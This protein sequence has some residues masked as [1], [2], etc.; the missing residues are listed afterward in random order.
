HGP[1]SCH[2]AMLFRH[3]DA[4]GTRRTAEADEASAR[5]LATTAVK[6]VYQH[7]SSPRDAQ[8]FEQRRALAQEYRTRH[9]CTDTSDT[10]PFFIGVFDTVAALSNYGSL[11]IL[12][13]LYGV[14]LLAASLT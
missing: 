1:L 5:K 2:G 13:G 14:V 9:A 4:N 8:F 11:A 10:F 3:S 7:V 12:A 6:S